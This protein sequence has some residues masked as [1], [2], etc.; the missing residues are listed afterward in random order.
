MPHDPSYDLKPIKTP[1]LRG[2]A[3]RLVVTLLERPVIRSLIAPWLTANLGL[4]ELRAAAI[5]EPPTFLPLYGGAESTGPPSAPEKRLTRLAPGPGFRFRGV[6]D[7]QSAYREG[8]ASPEQVAERAIAAIASSDRPPTPLRAFIACQADD[9]LSQARESTR[10]WKAG[11]PLGPLDGVPIAIKDEIDMAPYPTTAG[12]RFLGRAPAQT[13]STVVARLRSAGALLLGKANMHEIGILPD[14]LNPH[15][16]PVRNPYNLAHE[17]G[18]SSSGSAAAVAAGLCAAAVG[19][20]GGGSIRIPA[21]YCGVVGLKPTYGRVSEFG[22]VPLAP[23]VAH[24]G[25]IAATAEDAALLYAVIAGP[26]PK[27][28]NT[29]LQPPVRTGGFDGALEGVRIGIYRDWFSD[30]AGE[31]VAAC[32]QLLAQFVRLGAELVDVTIP[33]LRLIALAH[34][35][36]IHAEM[37]ANMERHDRE[38]RRGFS[39][40]TRLMLANVRALP[41]GDYVL[42]QRIRTRAMDRFR[43]ALTRAD[44][45]ATPATPLTALPISKHGLLDAETNVGRVVETMRF[46]NPANLTGLPAISLPCGYDGGLPVGLQLTGRPWDERTLFRLALAADTIVPRQPPA[47]YFHLLPNR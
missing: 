14:G 39:L 42:A 31:V 19:A 30:A 6:R 20:D 26:D 25:P 40:T 9:V 5:D 15:Y 12:T 38:R 4:R 18:G 36:T 24:L 22:A 1:W 28:P 8:A 3:L 7:Y 23:S 27:D 47:V 44:V 10:R 21:A 17:A 29:Q 46:T 41:S 33:D 35:L 11:K 13:D 45:I 16:G 43:A 32:E 2:A 34:G 37:A